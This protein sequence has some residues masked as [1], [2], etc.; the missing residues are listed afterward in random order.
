MTVTFSSK[1]SSTATP[2]R[3]GPAGGVGRAAGYRNLGRALKRA[4][5]P[6]K[7]VQLAQFFKTGPGEYGE[8]D[9]FLG[10]TVPQTRAIAR[11][12]HP[13]DFAVIPSLVRSPYHE[14][15]L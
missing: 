1:R 9:R 3:T 4:G 12:F 15:R 14:E 8:G 6:A 10:L 5:N 2:A 11:R 7:A 13:A